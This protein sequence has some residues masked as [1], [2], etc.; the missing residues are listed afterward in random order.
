[1]CNFVNL[2]GPVGERLFLVLYSCT[3]GYHRFRVEIF[4]GNLTGICLFIRRLFAGC[5]TAFV[6]EAMILLYRNGRIR[7]CWLGIASSGGLLSFEKWFRT[8][9]A[10]YQQTAEP[11][12]TDSGSIKIH[13]NSDTA[14]V[15]TVNAV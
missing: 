3:F 4:V 10:T 12:K 13:R 2:S 8:G 14:I 9:D 7:M 15:V 11:I 1:M 6:F 5:C